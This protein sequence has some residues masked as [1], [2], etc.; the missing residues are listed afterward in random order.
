MAGVHV[1]YRCIVGAN[2]VVTKH[3]PDYTVVG[4]VPA[5]PIKEYPPPADADVWLPELGR[6]D[7]I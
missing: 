5:K 6:P 7:G 1:G 3:V 2:S 4:G